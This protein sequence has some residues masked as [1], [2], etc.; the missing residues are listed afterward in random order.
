MK[1]L[2][3]NGLE[4]KIKSNVNNIGPI[5]VFITLI[6]ASGRGHVKEILQR[7]ITTEKFLQ[8]NYYRILLYH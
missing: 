8:K 7:R 2:C 1:K 6:L 3:Q 4:K 5:K